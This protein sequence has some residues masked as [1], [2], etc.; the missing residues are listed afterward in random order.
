MAD[1]TP[2]GFLLDEEDL[3]NISE[4]ELDE[5][6]RIA[7]RYIEIVNDFQKDIDEVMESLN[8]SA[9]YKELGV[10]MEIDIEYVYSIGQ[11]DE[12]E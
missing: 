8:E 9:V 11:R 12:D 5:V 7:E 2:D 4:E 6:E 3:E 1:V 10:K